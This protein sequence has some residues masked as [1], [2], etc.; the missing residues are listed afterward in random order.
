MAAG[1]KR[2]KAKGTPVI[3][4]Q[5]L[6]GFRDGAGTFPNFS[7]IKYYCRFV[8]FAFGDRQNAKA[9]RRHIV[10]LRKIDHDIGK[11]G[12]AC[13]EDSIFQASS[14]CFPASLV[15]PSID[16]DDDTVVPAF[17]RIF[18]P[19]PFRKFERDTSTVIVDSPANANWPAPATSG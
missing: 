11:T 2:R 14:E 13:L 4:H 16:A 15:N 1:K 17:E 8:R 6:R 10:E 3:E 19:S 9:A 18:H 12:L 7:F 5:E